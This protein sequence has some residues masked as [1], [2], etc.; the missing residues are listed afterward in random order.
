MVQEMIR[1]QLPDPLVEAVEF[2]DDYHIRVIFNSGEDGVEGDSVVIQC[3]EFTQLNIGEKKIFPSD[4]YKVGFW[5][6]DEGTPIVHVIGVE[7][8]AV[9]VSYFIEN[10][11]RNRVHSISGTEDIDDS[12]K[13]CLWLKEPSPMMKGMTNQEYA[14]KK[15]DERDNIDV[16]K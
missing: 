8:H 1:K 3:A 2:V 11:K 13:V 14:F 15:F 6:V 4:E 10:G 7:P 12:E 9:D 5:D 16:E